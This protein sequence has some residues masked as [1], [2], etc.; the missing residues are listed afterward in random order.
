[1]APREP[2][3]TAFGTTLITVCPSENAVNLLERKQK[4]N[5]Q[6]GL[7]ASR[8]GVVRRDSSLKLFSGVLL[9]TLLQRPG[10]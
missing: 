1:M 4:T 3:T 6:L 8:L 10:S 7:T 2:S 5:P 9:Y